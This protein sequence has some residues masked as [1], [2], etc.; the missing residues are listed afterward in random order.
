MELAK[1]SQH[2]IE[3][4]DH[5]VS[6]DSWEQF[7]NYGQGL[8]ARWSEFSLL[9]WGC[10][11]YQNIYDFQIV[12]IQLNGTQ[13]PPGAKLPVLKNHR[14]ELK[15]VMIRVKD[16]DV[17]NIKGWLVENNSDLWGMKFLTETVEST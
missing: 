11:P 9:T 7:L 17:P 10:R 5:S 2:W 15:C 13:N 14:F 8:R 3:G 12:Y 1:H 6:F 16:A 4:I